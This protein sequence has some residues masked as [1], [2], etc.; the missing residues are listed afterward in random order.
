MNCLECREFL[1]QHLDGAAIDTVLVQSHLAGCPDCR[2]LFEAARQLQR[3]LAGRRVAVASV[4]L[5]QRITHGILRDRARRRRRQQ[6]APALLAASLLLVVGLYVILTRR[7]NDGV[8]NDVVEHRTN[9]PNS[10]QQSL[11]EA[12]LA[13]VSLTY[14]TASETADQTRLLLPAAMPDA[15]VADMKV[16]QQ[17]ITSTGPSLEDAKQ[18]MLAG[19]EPV[20]L[21]ARR[22]VDLFLRELPPVGPDRKG[23]L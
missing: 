13:V 10:L 5:A 1:Q 4:D 14:R 23:G 9:F 19:L 6:L 8:R 20:T 17:S 12:G 18:G 22:A 3:G 11:E 16:L 21:S 7:P 2:G 15:P